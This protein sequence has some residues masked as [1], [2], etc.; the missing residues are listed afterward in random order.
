METRPDDRDRRIHQVV[1]QNK[2]S[3][4]DVDFGQISPAL[5]DNYF[6]AATNT[7]NRMATITAESLANKWCIGIETA[8]KTLRCTTQKGIRNTLHP[9]ERRFRTKQ[10]QLRYNQ[11]SGRHGRFYTDTFFASVPT[12]NGAS[13]A[14]LYINDLSFT[15]VYTMKQKSEV[16]DTLS[17]FIHDVGI[18]HALHSDD[19]PEL[20]QGRFRQLCKEYHIST[21]YTEPYSPWQNRAEG[22]IREIKRL[23]HRKMA[24]KRV[25]QK[26]WDFC[27]K[28][29]CEIKNKSAG[30]IYALE[31]RTPYEATLGNTPD[32]SSLIPFDFY[33][34]VWYHDE[35]SSFPESK[36]KLGRWLGEAA[37]FGQAMCYWILSENVKRIVQCIG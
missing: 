11:L 6:I 13:M 10:A 9:L 36:L 34:Y 37:D 3:N 33:D 2:N 29:A 35:V 20:M 31:E 19:A 18:R 15:K 32:I 5:D 22:G 17:K 28:W 26:L 4:F 23:V 14:Q 8:K 30:N 21:T 27:T 12:L 25:P 1:L 16:A 7:S 24:A